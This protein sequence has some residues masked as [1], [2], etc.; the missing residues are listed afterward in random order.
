MLISESDTDLGWGHSYFDFFLPF[1]EYL[2]I[3]SVMA[4]GVMVAQ[5]GAFLL[6]GRALAEIPV[7]CILPIF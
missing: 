5:V 7:P 2:T 1:L 6:K 4:V 3:S